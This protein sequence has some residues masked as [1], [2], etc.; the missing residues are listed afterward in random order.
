MKT[1]R[2]AYTVV[3]QY[4]CSKMVFDVLPF[5]NEHAAMMCADQYRKRP[6]CGYTAQVWIR[7]MNNGRV[8]LSGF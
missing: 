3:V 2:K 8:D 1:N 6:G 5:T 7:Y 4:E